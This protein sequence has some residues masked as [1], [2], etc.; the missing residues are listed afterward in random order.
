MRDIQ[1]QD[2][3]AEDMRAD[4]EYTRA[5]NKTGLFVASALWAAAIVP[6]AWLS[7]VLLSIPGAFGASFF[8]LP[9]LFFI[10]GAIWFGPYGWL[11]AAVGTFVGGALAGSPLAINIAQNPIPAFLANTMLLWV[12]FKAFRIKV[13][14]GGPGIAGKNVVVA[15]IAVVVTVTLSMLG[16]WLSAPVIGQWGYVVA[17]LATLVG[18]VLLYR[19]GAR[20]LGLDRHVIL[21]VVAVVITS[22]VSAVMGGLAWATL[23]GM[24]VSAFVIVAPGWFLGDTVA[25]SLS[26]AVLWAFHHEMVKRDLVWRA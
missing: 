20:N 13:A 23:G 7:S 16:G 8:W 1:D 6:A 26:V 24:G 22:L 10:T 12:L 18:W 5:E 17:F 3:S 2:V 9:M 4:N 25:G 19:L 14:A 21:A 11:A 15:L